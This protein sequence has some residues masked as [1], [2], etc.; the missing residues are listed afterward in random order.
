MISHLESHP[1]VY[2]SVADLAAYW[3]V[4]RKQI[5]KQ[6]QA[7]TL[8]AV[9]IGPRLLR[10]RTAEAIKFERVAKLAPALAQRPT[11]A[12]VRHPLPKKT[13]KSARPASKARLG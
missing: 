7:G 4:S 5:Y 13:S 3:C 11:P 10:I 1:D 12:V 2:V 8:S 6:I 9:R